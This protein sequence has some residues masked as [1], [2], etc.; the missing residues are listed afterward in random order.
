VLGAPVTIT[1]VR[2]TSSDEI[3]AVCKRDGHTGR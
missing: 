3:L 1:R 2:V